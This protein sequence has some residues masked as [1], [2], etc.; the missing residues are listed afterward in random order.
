M[1]GT[2]GGTVT[3]TTHRLRYADKEFGRAHY[4]SFLVEEISS[5]EVKY[6]AKVWYLYFG[7]LWVFAAIYFFMTGIS[8]LAILGV[9]LA[10]FFGGLYVS[11][12]PHGVRILSK[13]GS[14]INFHASGMEDSKLLEFMNTLESTIKNRREI[15][16]K[17]G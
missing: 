13:G 12:R 5:I 15:L 3:L 6:S 14:K 10:I 11:S 7:A 9:I 16:Y 2:D 4:V 1:T 17:V 8:M